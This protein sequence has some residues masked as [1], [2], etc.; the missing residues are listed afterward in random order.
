MLQLR[1]GYAPG[2]SRSGLVGGIEEP[3][4]SSIVF[5]QLE[6]GRVSSYFQ[7]QHSLSEAVHHLSKAAV[8]KSE[9]AW[10]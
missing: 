6:L 2:G 9:L 7:V 4:S 8:E 5:S 1:K 3:I 10:S